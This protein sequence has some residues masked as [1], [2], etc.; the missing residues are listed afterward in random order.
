[1]LRR[2][3]WGVGVAAA[4]AGT[5]AASVVVMAPPH[6]SAEPIN[7]FQPAA[8]APRAGPFEAS[9]PRGL[10]ANRPLHHRHRVVLGEW[11]IVSA[12][13]AKDPRC[14]SVSLSLSVSR[15]VSLSL[16]VSLCL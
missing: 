3:G 6:A 15:C 11:P 8:V 12:I 5:A 1:M 10:Q 13:A 14:V 16:T 4:A 9:S 7:P 2:G